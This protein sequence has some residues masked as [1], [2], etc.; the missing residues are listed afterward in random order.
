MPYH[1]QLYPCVV[2][3]AKVKGKAKRKPM[4]KL[5]ANLPFGNP[6]ICAQRSQG[7]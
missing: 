3:Y 4:G 1:L 6:S 7:R 2:G 5:K